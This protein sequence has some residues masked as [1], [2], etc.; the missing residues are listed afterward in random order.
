MIG[1]AFKLLLKI[2]MLPDAHV[3][4]NRYRAM[5]DDDEDDDGEDEEVLPGTTLRG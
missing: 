2:C 1:T 3:K 4:C 5:L